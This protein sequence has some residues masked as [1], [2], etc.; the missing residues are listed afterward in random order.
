M[1]DSAVGELNIRRETTYAVD[2]PAVIRYVM[3][4]AARLAIVIRH[5]LRQVG[6][7]VEIRSYDWGRFYGDIKAGRLQMYGLS[8]V[9]FKTADIFRYI[10]HSASIP[11]HH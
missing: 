8:C 4:G 1:Q 5:Q 2:R 11:R 9:G 7:D 3:G 6:I 10:F